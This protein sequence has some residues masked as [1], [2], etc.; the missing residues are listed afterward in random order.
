MPIRPFSPSVAGSA[1][2]SFVAVI[3]RAPAQHRCAQC[4]GV[5]TP[6]LT[7]GA[8][9]RSGGRQIRAPAAG[10]GHGAAA[11]AG[12]GLP[13]AGQ[14]AGGAAGLRPCRLLAPKACSLTA[15]GRRA[16]TRPTSACCPRSACL[17][18]SCRARVR[19]LDLLL[20]M[21]QPQPAVARCLDT[22]HHPFN[23]SGLSLQPCRFRSSEM[24]MLQ[25][26]RMLPRGPAPAACP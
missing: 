1:G 12:R 25:P 13:H 6:W 20:R 7:A 21:H 3:A 18:A 22:V 26:A 4:K 11:A 24:H 8:L 23:R 16:C 19:A 2:M 9:P 15:A 10:A 14:P 17:T 5:R